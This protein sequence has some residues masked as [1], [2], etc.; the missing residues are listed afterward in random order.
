MRRAVIVLVALA[1]LIACHR[2]S[3]RA[4]LNPTRAPQKDIPSTR[5]TVAAPSQM[6]LELNEYEIRM[7]DSLKAGHQ[8]FIVV[9][10]GKGNHSLVIEG[11]NGFRTALSQQL[12]RGDAAQMDVDFKPGTYTF[13]CPVDGH[14]GKGMTRTVTVQ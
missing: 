6:R 12:T 13:Y 9:N 1:A 7:P 11:P 10:S 5:P 3:G 4:D 2:E 14:R 8:S